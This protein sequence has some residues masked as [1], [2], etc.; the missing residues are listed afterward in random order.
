LGTSTPTEKLDVVGNIN[1][2]GTITSDSI[3][4]ASNFIGD[5][6]EL[7]G[8]KIISTDTNGDIE[9]EPNG[10]GEVS[11]TSDINISSGHEYK[12]NGVAL[13]ASNVGAASSDHSH[14]NITNDGKIGTTTNLAVVTGTGGAIT[15]R[16]ISDSTANA[17][18]GSSIYFV[19][20][21]DIY[22]GLTKINN[23]DQSR[24]TTI[25][26]PTSGGTYNEILTSVSSTSTPT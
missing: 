17:A 7:N 8:R 12:I 2:T 15:T 20:E 26:A 11:I 23:S 24:A 14:G 25:Y 9:I 21:R 10:T 18:I 4:Q 3:I 16:N 6:L 22:Y 5:N 1:V 13:S 19:T